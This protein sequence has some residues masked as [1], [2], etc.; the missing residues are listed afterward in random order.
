MS[1]NL[2]FF[3]RPKRPGTDFLESHNCLAMKRS[4][5]AGRCT[6]EYIL[7]DGDKTYDGC[8]EFISDENE[9]TLF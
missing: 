5:S 1:S 9:G 4:L 6:F 8:Q 7:Q 2:H 3:E